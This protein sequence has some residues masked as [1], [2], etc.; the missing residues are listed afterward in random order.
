MLSTCDHYMFQEQRTL[1]MSTRIDQLIELFDKC[2]FSLF[3]TSWNSKP[4]Y[5]DHWS[6]KQVIQENETSQGHCITIC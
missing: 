4:N 3:I 5:F 2:S 1:N 6:K